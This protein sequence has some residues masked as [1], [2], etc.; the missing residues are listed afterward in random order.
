MINEEE[1]K[2]GEKST[3]DR[4]PTEEAATAHPV[5]SFFN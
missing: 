3:L 2:T 1:V 5:V 4:N